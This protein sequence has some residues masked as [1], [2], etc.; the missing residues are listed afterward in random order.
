MSKYDDF[1]RANEAA[2]GLVEAIA[3]E[4][5]GNYTF[6]R[7]GSF[8]IETADV[9]TL[10]SKLENLPPEMDAFTWMHETTFRNYSESNP[11]AKNNP[12]DDFDLYDV[13]PRQINVGLLK[14]N[15]LNKYISIKGLDLAKII[16]TKSP[17]FT[18]DPIENARCGAR[19]LLRQGQSVIVGSK[20]NQKYT[21]F[22][23][24][25]LSTWTTMPLD[26]KNERRIVA[27]TGPEARPNRLASWQKF[28]P[29]FK[30]FFE[31]FQK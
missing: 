14:A 6:R 18:G 25:A 20:N 31:E 24:V 9:C 4:K 30:K 8:T 28:G 19:I 29:M 22:P 17:L 13:G 27:F 21:M 10:I 7:Y 15:I 23:P 11:N 26:E 16:G 1:W 5:A 2:G 12:S 3:N